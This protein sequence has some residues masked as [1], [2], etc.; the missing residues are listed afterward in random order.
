MPSTSPEILFD[1]H[2]L[3][4]I[5]ERAARI[6]KP[7]ADF[8]VREA[9]VT[10]IDRLSVTNRH[11]EVGVD[12]CGPF[13][14]LPDADNLENVGS[15]FHLS[16]LESRSK[17]PGSLRTGQSKVTLDHFPL[18]PKSV[19]LITSIFV[20]HWSNDIPAMLK[21][22]RR[23]LQPDGLFMAAF[24]GQKTLE[25]L[26]DCLLKAEA[27]LNGNATLRIDPFGEIRQVGNLLQKAG[28]TLPVVD[29]DVLTVRYDTMF[30]LIQDLRG[31]GATSALANYSA[32][33]PKNLFELASEIYKS[34]Y[35]DPDGRI[36]VT[37]EIVY[38]SGWADHTSQQKP[39][40]PGSAKNKLS[41]FL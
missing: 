36:R 38:L 26:R 34:D 23:A 13:N 9:A 20:L 3:L 31:M 24:P 40:A 12:F 6:N 4:A 14:A 16:P 30:D 22:I 15:F 5:W 39:L 11:F 10:I 37:F 25:E 17:I 29:S 18:L 7:G 1:H 19:N 27:K 21:Q 33:G 35:S 28:F 41:D 32:Y 8:L 2:R